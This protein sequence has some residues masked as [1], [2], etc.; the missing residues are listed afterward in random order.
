MN[1][2]SKMGA[3]VGVGILDVKHH[4]G[5]LQKLDSVFLITHSTVTP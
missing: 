5:K 4:L 2:L 3:I 1:R